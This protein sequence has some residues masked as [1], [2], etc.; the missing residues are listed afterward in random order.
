[1]SVSGVGTG[2]TSRRDAPPRPLSALRGQGLATELRMEDQGCPLTGR[3]R[4]AAADPGGGSLLGQRAGQA[5]RLSRSIR[6]TEKE[7]TGKGKDPAGDGKSR[8]WRRSSSPV[9]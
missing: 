9:Y 5:R 2:H 7:K 4:G 3:T 1:M 8:S 6:Q